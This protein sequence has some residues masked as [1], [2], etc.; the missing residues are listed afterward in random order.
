M[1]S[2]MLVREPSQR[3]TLDGIMDHSWLELGDA[4]P[5]ETPLV[6]T[7]ELSGDDLSHIIQRMVDGN[8]ATKEDII[9]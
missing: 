7:E 9:E 4:L 2:R 1:I 8:I 3:A 5:V 6:C